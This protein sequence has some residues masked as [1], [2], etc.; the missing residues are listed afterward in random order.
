[1]HCE[2]TNFIAEKDDLN[3]VDSLRMGTPPDLTYGTSKQQNQAESNEAEDIFWMIFK[4]IFL[5]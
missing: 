5:L 4:L 2:K 3:L 1:M